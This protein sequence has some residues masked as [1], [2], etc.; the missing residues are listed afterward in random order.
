MSQEP[1]FVG[2]LDKL[3][4]KKWAPIILAYPTPGASENETPHRE[5][6][7][8]AYERAPDEI[9]QALL[10]LIDKDNENHGHIFIVDKV[11]HCWDTRIAAA[12]LEKVGN[13]ALKSDSMEVLLKHLLEHNVAE[14]KSCAESLIQLPIS[15]DHKGKAVS[16]AKVLILHA[17]D[18]G[19]PTV[20]PAMQQDR[21][22]GRQVALTVAHRAD[23][24]LHPT[25]SQLTE[26]KVSQQT[27][28]CG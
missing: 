4:W 16:A 1:E 5:L 14:A 24:Q 23:E 28:T 6:V 12:F 8:L 19:W 26:A 25:V 18:C 3:V 10:I 20:W 11:L 13:E 21:D 27:F 22:F 17:A 15:T 2:Q 7:K 9:I